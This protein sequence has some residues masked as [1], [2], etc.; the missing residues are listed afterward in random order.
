MTAMPPFDRARSPDS[1]SLRDT[2][3]SSDAQLA[4]AVPVLQHLLSARDQSLFSD[5]IVARVRGMLIDL[6][7]QLLRIQAE[8]TG[9]KAREAFAAQHGEALAERLFASKPLVAHCHALAIEWQLALE[10]EGRLSLDTV[11]SPLLQSLVGHEDSEVAG[12]AMAA[13]AAQTRFA[14][15]QRRMEL[16]L[17][18]LA[19]DLFHATIELWRANAAGSSV[20]A[21][22]RAVTRL[23]SGFDEGNTRRALFARL[24]A[25]LPQ[26]ASAMAI[27]KAGVALFLSAVADR[28]GRDRDLIALSTNDSQLAR[29]A[30]AL[31]AAGLKP[32]EIDAQLLAIHP[33]TARQPE[34]DA[35]G[36]REASDALAGTGGARS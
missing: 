35:I 21:L 22:S 14:R 34:I 31:R 8:A 24:A 9:E 29:L 16:P 2:L 23:R 4:A 32:D 25:S 27:G 36:I 7:W 18:E 26:E 10:L 11:L 17:Q 6:A 20:D 3:A 33:G 15:T 1:A 19:G 13:L 30:V 28:T 12:L 5:R